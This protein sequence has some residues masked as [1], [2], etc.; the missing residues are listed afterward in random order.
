MKSHFIWLPYNI[1]YTDL[2]IGANAKL[3]SSNLETYNSF[4]EQT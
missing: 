3:I 2:Y 4:S 1:P